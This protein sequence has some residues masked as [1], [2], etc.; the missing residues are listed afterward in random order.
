[1]HTVLAG[2]YLSYFWRG[3][4]IFWTFIFYM[5][6][7]QTSN[8]SGLSKNDVAVFHDFLTPLFTF[9][10]LFINTYYGSSIFAQFLTPA[11]ALKLKEGNVI[12]GQ[13]LVILRSLWIDVK[14]VHIV[15][16]KLYTIIVNNVFQL[17]F[18]VNNTCLSRGFWAK[19][20]IL[21]TWFALRTR[22]FLNYTLDSYNFQSCFFHIVHNSIHSWYLFNFIF[23]STSH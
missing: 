4:S 10:S 9:E 5:Y 2:N 22:F 3:R 15:K 8:P 1:M 13:P 23:P 7:L 12:Y 20:S 11:S 19:F 6:H 16:C 14:E 21:V 18:F 17:F